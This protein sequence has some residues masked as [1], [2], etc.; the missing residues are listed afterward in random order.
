MGIV[1]LTRIEH[2]N[3]AHRLYNPLWSDEKNEEVYGKCA[4]ANWH[5][6]NFELY[7]TVKGTPSSETGFVMDAKKLSTIVNK[8]I[9]DIVD[10]RNL[11]IDVPF[12]EG[13]ITS[14]ENLVIGIWEI[15]D[16]LIPSPAKLHC[17]KLVE[18]PRI[19]IEYFG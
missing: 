11:N 8:S 17:V 9:I 10:H 13:K 4:N 5:G 7:V 3:A 1:Y 16:P 6:H 15:L 2:F 19:F 14:I 18:T 12:M